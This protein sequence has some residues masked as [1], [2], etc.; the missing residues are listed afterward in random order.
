M[1][2]II[3]VVDTVQNSSKISEIGPQSLFCI[4]YIQKKLVNRF[5]SSSIHFKEHKKLFYIDKILKKQIILGPFFTGSTTK[6]FVKIVIFFL[7]LF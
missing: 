7:S 5:S 4:L 2:P 1:K 3:F 6:F